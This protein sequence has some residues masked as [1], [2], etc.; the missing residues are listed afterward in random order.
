[1]IMRAFQTAG[2]RQDQVMSMATVKHPGK[3]NF[4]S[5]ALQKIT[6]NTSELTT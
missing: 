2:V 6:H 5:L 4:I 3:V 1:M